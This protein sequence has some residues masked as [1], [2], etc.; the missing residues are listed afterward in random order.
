[1][2]IV[3]CIC[4]MVNAARARVPTDGMLFAA[5]A[6]DSGE[7]GDAAGCTQGEIG[8]INPVTGQ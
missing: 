8:L 2:L 3:L 5:T 7:V 4:S 1:M 6:S